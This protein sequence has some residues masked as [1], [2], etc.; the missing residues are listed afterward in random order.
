MTDQRKQPE[1][2]H[3]VTQTQYCPKDVQV[4]IK[5]YCL[6]KETS[7]VTDDRNRLKLVA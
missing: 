7:D 4:A 2:C 3:V 5:L 6:T 1:H